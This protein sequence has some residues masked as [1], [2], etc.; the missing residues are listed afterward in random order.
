MSRRSR[1]KT[2]RRERKARRRPAERSKPASPA[3]ERPKLAGPTVERHETPGPAVEPPPPSASSGEAAPSLAQVEERG[4]PLVSVLARVA[5]ADG[6]PRTKLEGAMEILFGAYGES[7][8]DFS[9]LFL[10]GWLHARE[11]KEF[12]LGLAWQR[13]Q[14][15]LTLRDILAEGVAAGAFRRDLDP[16]AVSAVILNTAEG[17]LL[18]AATEGGAVPAAELLRTLLALVVSAA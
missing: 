7:D 14:I 6:V 3:A 12:R 9:A 2:A 1:R 16:T 17:C 15:R 10:K 18:Q 13:E 4:L 5:Q 11:D 8:L